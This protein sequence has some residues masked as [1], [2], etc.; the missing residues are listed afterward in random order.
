MNQDEW[1]LLLFKIILVADVLAI[2]LFVAQYWWLTR[3]AMWHNE[4]GR[5][6]VVKDILLILCLLPSI[7]SLF[8]TFNRLTS[9]IAAWVDV[10]LFGLLA[11]VM[12][13]RVRV[14]QRIHN[15]KKPPGEESL[16]VRLFD[17]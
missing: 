1:L 12:L 2:A 8:F 7:M 9:H 3:G 6:I 5:T 13:W 14:W 15:T 11:P 10:A 17:N 16:C 4:I